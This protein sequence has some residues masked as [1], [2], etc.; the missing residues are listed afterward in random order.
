METKKILIA[1]DDMDLVIGL[2]LRLKSEGY[3]VITAVD[4]YQALAQAAAEWPDLIILD[5]NMP[6][7]SGL[8]VQE[9]LQ[10]MS[11][12]LTI[13]IVYLTGL[14]LPEVD[15]LAKKP[16][17]F[18]VVHKPYDTAEFL[19]IIRRACAPGIGLAEAKGA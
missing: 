15:A 10:K 13:P 19:E 8:T 18:A 2:A 3:E 12:G 14:K 1:D 7:G 16:G 6:C 4:G 11:R 9:R 5:I 17:V